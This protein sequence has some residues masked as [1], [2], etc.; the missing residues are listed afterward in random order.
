MSD[1]GSVGN[2]VTTAQRWSDEAETARSATV[3]QVRSGSPGIG[4]VRVSSQPWKSSAASS[5]GV[6]HRKKPIGSCWTAYRADWSKTF[7]A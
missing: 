6:S 3:S 4:R 2:S 7:H 5:P 1:S